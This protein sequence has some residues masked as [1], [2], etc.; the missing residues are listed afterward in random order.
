MRKKPK[1]DLVARL[2]VHFGMG[3]TL[4]MILAFGLIYSNIGHVGEMIQNAFDPYGTLVEF[5]GSMVLHF[6][7]GAALTGFILMEVDRTEAN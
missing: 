5:V 7:I 3:A 4:G 6:G 2:A 1:N